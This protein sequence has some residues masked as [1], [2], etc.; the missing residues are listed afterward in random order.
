MNA[1][2]KNW[3]LPL[4]AFIAVVASAMFFSAPV[5]AIGSA[6]PPGC[7]QKCTNITDKSGDEYSHCK[8]KCGLK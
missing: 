2:S 8:E 7:E 1:L 4:A 6:L 3:N 5:R